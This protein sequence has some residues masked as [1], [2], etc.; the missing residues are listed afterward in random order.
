MKRNQ[1]YFFDKIKQ[2]NKTV[3]GIFNVSTACAIF[4]LIILLVMDNGCKKNETTTPMTK[5]SGFH[6][7]NLVAG[8]IGFGAISIDTN[9][10]NA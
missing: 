9:L 10:N 7:I 8:T 3:P 1:K 5:E 6:R 2:L 4:I